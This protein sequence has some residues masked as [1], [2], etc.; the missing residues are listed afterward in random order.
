MAQQFG[1]VKMTIKRDFDKLRKVYGL[2]CR[3]GAD[4]NGVWLLTDKG[5]A[6]YQHLN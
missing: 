1:V 2:V 4:K 5:M 6:V 3:V